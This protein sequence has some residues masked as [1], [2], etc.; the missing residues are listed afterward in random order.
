[1]STSAASSASAIVKQ[2]S[3]FLFFVLLS[4]Y[5]FLSFFLFFPGTKTFSIKHFADLVEYDTAGFLEKNKDTVI[6]EQVRKL[7][8]IL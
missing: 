6:E 4:L 2:C 3:K 8:L 1:M 7:F 5:H